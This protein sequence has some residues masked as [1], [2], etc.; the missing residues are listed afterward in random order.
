MAVVALQH[1]FGASKEVA[2]LFED[3]DVATTP[4]IGAGDG[5]T[6][7]GE[8]LLKNHVSGFSTYARTF[9]S[10]PHLESISQKFMSN[11]AH[12]TELLDIKD[13]WVEFPD[14]YNFLQGLVS[15]ATIE[16]L[17]GSKIFEINPNIVED[18]WTFERGTPQFIRCLPRWLMPTQYKARDR[19]FDTL[20]KLDDLASQHLSRLEPSNPDWEPYLGSK[21]LRARHEY[22]MFLN[23]LPDDTKAWEKM[24]IM[25][26]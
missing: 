8:A 16:A 22:G 13:D 17:M 4:S 5:T 3:D 20:K 6:P 21:F 1:L 23:P 15:R 18:F 26:G 9:L 7:E 25:F 2:K 19:I 24:G 11:L 12:N 14:L 10:G